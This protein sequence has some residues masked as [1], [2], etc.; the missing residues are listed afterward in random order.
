MSKSHSNEDQK[1]IELEILGLF[2]QVAARRNTPELTPSM[3][4]QRLWYTKG[5]EYP[6]TSVRRALTVLTTKGSLQKLSKTKTGP[7][8]KPEHFWK[9]DTSGGVDGVQK[10]LF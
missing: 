2:R 5:R 8:G 7:Y 6:I 9:L 10:D 3:V 1:G 4:H